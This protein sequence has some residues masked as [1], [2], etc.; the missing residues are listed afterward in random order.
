MGQIKQIEQ[1]KS[2]PTLVKMLDDLMVK[3]LEAKSSVVNLQTALSNISTSFKDNSDSVKELNQVIS[4]LSKGTSLNSETVGDLLQKYPELSKYAKKTA[5]GWTI[6]KDAVTALRDEK[7]TFFKND[8][9]NEKKNAISVVNASLQRMT[10]Y[11]LQVKTVNN[12][13]EAKQALLDIDKQM[14]SPIEKPPEPNFFGSFMPKGFAEVLSKDLLKSVDDYTNTVDKKN[15]EAALAQREQIQKNIEAIED[16]ISTGEA[17]AKGLGDPSL[18]VSVDKGSMDSISDT[19]ELLTDLQKKLKDNQKAID[20]LLNRRNRLRKDSQEY[21]D[22]LKKENKLLQEQIDLRNDGIKHPE[23]LVSAKVTTTVKG[24]NPTL[25]G[26]NASSSSVDKMLSNALG[27]QGEFKY[28]QVSGKFKGTYDEF[29]DG[30]V[31]DCSQFVQEMFDEFLNVNLPRTA[32]EQAKQ[33]VAVSKADLKAGDLVF[34]NTNG[35]DNS[36]VGIYSGNGKMIQMGDSGLKESDINSS[37]WADKYQGARRISNTDT[38]VNGSGTTKT[39]DG[40]TTVKTQYGTAKEKQDAIDAAIEAN[41]KDDDAIYQNNLLQLD[42]I[43][44]KYERLIKTEELKIEASQRKQ[45]TFD[46]NS[47]EWRKENDKQTNIQSLIQSLKKQEESNLTSTMKE[48]KIESNEYDDIR[49]DLVNDTLNIQTEKYAQQVENINSQIDASKDKIAE[50]DTLIEQSKNRMTHY[51]EGSPEYNKELNYQIELT[52]K[53]RMENESLRT[54]LNN[55]MQSQKLDN[56]TKKDLKTILDHLNVMDYTADIKNLNKTLIDSK[57]IPLEDKLSEL[58]YELELSEARIKGLKEGTEEYNKELNDQIS[59][60]NKQI[61]TTNKLKEYYETQSENEE[62]LAAD[63]E[64]AKKKVQELTLS[65]YKY[66]D[67]IK[68]IRE[69][70]ADNVISNLKKVYE[71]QQKLQNA[72]YDKEKELE[73]K[74][75]E[76]KMDNLDDEYSKFEDMINGQLK[77]IDRTTSEED[78]QDQLSKLLKEK[79][80]L[81]SR[82]SNLQL[83]TSFEAKAKRVDLQ[84]EIDAKAEEIAKLQRDRG[85]EL[86]K[87][88]LQDQLDDRKETIEKEKKAETEKN[89]S[90]IENIEALKK[91]NDEYYDGL[92]NDEQ[93]FYNMKQALMS[94]DTVKIQ[95]ELT[96]VQAAYDTFFKELEKNSGVYA[97]KIANNLKYS[98]GLD[99]DYVNNF[100]TTENS[101][102]NS[103]G[104][105]TN[106]VTEESKNTPVDSMNK[107]NTAWNEYLS[108]KQKAEQMQTEMK[109]LLKDSAEY[110]NRRAEIAKLQAINEGYRKQYGFQDGSYEYLFNL[111]KYHTGGEVGVEG[112]TTQ[113]WWEKLLK[114]DESLAVLRNKEVVLDEPQ[115]FINQIA[116]NAQSNMSNISNMMVTKSSDNGARSIE[117]TQKFE[118]GNMYNVDKN[119]IRDI[120]KAAGNGVREAVKM[121][122]KYDL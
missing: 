65:L 77:T 113:K 75:H 78:H 110:K 83:D 66:G 45:E 30:A 117:V 34:F 51:A 99:K 44:E 1:I 12:L 6:E 19:T 58:S 36:H 69:T 21:R 87:Q 96:I 122:K 93:F 63:R 72:A 46:P 98:L 91:K 86:N 103:G 40:D 109:T 23:K 92:L 11:G 100:P 28:K 90:F 43:R 61:E 116:S 48:L 18:G 60:I 37:Y 4:D 62:L 118:F 29:V 33:G 15:K 52:K 59:I 105:T 71:E 94:G 5:N 80:D 38:S 107:R 2:N 102:N 68:D 3:S 17:F 50:W 7:V 76:A 111:T 84:K 8:L 14:A 112:T 82:Y 64:E 101:G 31:S 54:T 24:E 104:N 97:S 88:G 119:A 73:N 47:A 74:R 35:K 53:Q 55:L 41:K 16:L 70:Y 49:R 13:A 27:L 22:S 32:A 108:N 95:N 57:A 39:K 10:A 120:G 9:E 79:S 121:G 20:D 42:S 106:P 67:A 115:R 56:A 81:D 25:D 85:I 89:K 26:A 114:K